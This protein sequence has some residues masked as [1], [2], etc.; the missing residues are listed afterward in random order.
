MIK[1]SRKSATKNFTFCRA[2]CERRAAD[3]HWVGFWMNLKTKANTGNPQMKAG[4]H[5][6]PK[7]LNFYSLSC[8]RGVF[9]HWF[10]QGNTW[11]WLFPVERVNDTLLHSNTFFRRDKK[12]LLILQL[13]C[14]VIPL[15]FLC[16]LSET[17]WSW[18]F[19][20]C[21]SSSSSICKR[22]NQN[23]L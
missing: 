10:I 16:L 13:N 3:F 7:L 11:L 23:K 1:T 6:L 8:T 4:G 5:F 2:C 21:A 12:N 18:S 20:I 15:C 14:V 22:L 17:S 19:L 9:H